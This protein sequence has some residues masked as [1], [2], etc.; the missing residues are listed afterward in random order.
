VA[1]GSFAFTKWYIDCLDDKG[2]LVILYWTSL[3]WR[4][5]RLTWHSVTHSAPG[6]APRT[7]SSIVACDP[8][9][10]AAGTIRW[11]SKRLH[12]EVELHAGVAAIAPQELAP[13][14]LWTCAAPAAR[15]IVRVG[16]TVFRGTGYAEHIQLHVPPWQLGI[17]RLRW[18][19]WIGDGATRSVVWIEWSGDTDRRWVFLDG[20]A[21]DAGRID[22]RSVAAGTTTLTLDDGTVVI[23]RRVGAAI[24]K[25]AALRAIAP[26]WLMAARETRRTRTGT[27][28]DGHTETRGT[29]VDEVVEFG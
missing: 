24:G 21:S 18:G 16:D 8:P 12:C 13:G 2:S 9:V 5:L 25:I 15:A 23:D 26:R 7:R 1:R 6:A 29:A 10:E 28:N 3:E 22:E 11:S 17:R 19:R 27:L 14:V 4:R 20:L